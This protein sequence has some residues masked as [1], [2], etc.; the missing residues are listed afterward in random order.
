M[1]RGRK[2]PTTGHP[3]RRPKSI[4]SSTWLHCLLTTN[5]TRGY[6]IKPTNSTCNMVSCFRLKDHCQKVLSKKNILINIKTNKGTP[7]LVLCLEF[8]SVYID[9]FLFL[10]KSRHLPYTYSCYLHLKI[11]LFLYRLKNVL[12]CVNK[13][14][15]FFRL[16]TKYESWLYKS[17][18]VIQSKYYRM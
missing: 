4:W 2:M 10:L 17:R 11:R 1:I 6:H 5:D 3:S 16:L 8:A 15:D 18:K 13:H 14:Y 9:L 12:R 7:K